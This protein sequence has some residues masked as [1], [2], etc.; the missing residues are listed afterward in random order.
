VTPAGWPVADS[1][2]AELNPPDTE[3]V[4]VDVP[5]FPTT[6]ET[7]VGYAESVNAGVVLVGASSLISATPFGLPHPVTRS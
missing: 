7:E 2:M 3:V 6:T 4:T 5:L 1:A